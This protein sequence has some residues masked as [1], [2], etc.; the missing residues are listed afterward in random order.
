MLVIDHQ[1]FCFQ[2][3]IKLIQSKTWSQ[4]TCNRSFLSSLAE[5]AQNSNFFT[6]TRSWQYYKQV[7][8]TLLTLILASYYLFLS[9]W[10]SNLQK[11]HLL[12]KS[13]KSIFFIAHLGSSICWRISM[14]ATSMVYNFNYCQSNH[15]FC[16]VAWSIGL[17]D[18][19]E[20]YQS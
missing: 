9:L 13:F 2:F 1:S 3:N 16:H 19:F 7:T 11:W 14:V 4:K 5:W 20:R 15:H 10:M 8:T 17:G 18:F 12:Y 6:S